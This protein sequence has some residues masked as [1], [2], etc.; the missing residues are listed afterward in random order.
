M[1]S[2]VDGNFVVVPKFSSQSLL[3]V[4]ST[5]AKSTWH[6]FKHL[7]HIYC[8]ISSNMC[9]AF[10]L[11]IPE[12]VQKAQAKPR[13]GAT[14]HDTPGAARGAAGAIVRG[15]AGACR[16]ERRRRWRSIS[17]RCRRPR[18]QLQRGARPGQ[19]RGRPRLV[20]ARTG[21]RLVGRLRPGRPQRAAAA[22]QPPTPWRAAT[23]QAIQLR[24][25]PKGVQVY[26]LL[27]YDNLF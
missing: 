13:G 8:Q 7:P 4:K 19:Q 25:L 16:Q 10:V 17:R 3:Q 21:A 9:T 23:C 22:R 15:A 24:L 11:Q 6:V 1:E 27:F 12:V 5:F 20:G 2:K 26:M 14:A 18:D